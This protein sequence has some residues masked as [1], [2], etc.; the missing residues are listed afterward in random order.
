MRTTVWCNDPINPPH[1]AEMGSSRMNG[2]RYNF[3]IALA[4]VAIYA[5]AV[6]TGA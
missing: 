1:A 3:W 4:V 2:A 5:L 6:G